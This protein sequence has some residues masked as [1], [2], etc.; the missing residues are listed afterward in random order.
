[1]L[2]TLSP[3]SVIKALFHNFLSCPSLS[4]ARSPLSLPHFIIKHMFSIKSTTSPTSLPRVP[5]WVSFWVTLGLTAQGSSRDLNI[6]L[7]KKLLYQKASVETK[8]SSSPWRLDSDESDDEE[9]IRK[10]T[11]P[12][13][14]PPHL[15][16]WL[17][18]LNW[19]Y[20]L[21]PSQFP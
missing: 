7:S 10:A 13:A 3:P 2:L 16:S 15:L 6:N 5:Y 1:M 18:V 12:E 8:G 14:R 9:D 11:Q 19:T 21:E 4:N 17:F 20:Q